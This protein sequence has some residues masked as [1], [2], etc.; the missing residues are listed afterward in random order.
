MA[1]P[2]Q[3]SLFLSWHALNKCV[4]LRPERERL[5]IENKSRPDPHFERVKLKLILSKCKPSTRAD[6]HELQV[7]CTCTHLHATALSPSPCRFNTERLVKPHKQVQVWNLLC[8]FSTCVYWLGLFVLQHHWQT[9]RCSVTLFLHAMT[10]YCFLSEFFPLCIVLHC[11]LPDG[12]LRWWDCY[13]FALIWMSFLIT[14]IWN[15]IIMPWR[16]HSSSYLSANSSMSLVLP[17]RILLMY[18]HCLSSTLDLFGQ[19]SIAI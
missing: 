14:T 19:Y 1:S 10:I 12:V 11:L 15:F 2:S 16:G 3:F 7:L 13:T 4:C 18:L 6:T 8:L 17:S 9:V 5:F